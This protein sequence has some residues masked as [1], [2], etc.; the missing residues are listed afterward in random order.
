MV[1]TGS[2]G[3]EGEDS[4][5]LP[6]W[7]FN[8]G[9]TIIQ[10]Q[11]VHHKNDRRASH[12]GPLEFTFPDGLLTKL[13][14]THIKQGHKV[15]TQA[16]GEKVVHLFVSRYSNPFSA[17]TFN[18]YWENLMQRVDT[19]GQ[20]YFAPSLART[21]YVEDYT[22]EQGVHPDMWDGAAAVMGNSVNVW[23]S[24]NPSKRKR[25]AQRAVDAHTE[26]VTRRLHVVDE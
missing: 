23:S 8:Y 15:L 5:S 24:Y 11:V 3:D 7:H 16:K 17:T 4:E 14:L 18:H 13:L 6:P 9:S 10:I 1:A 19:M 21:M 20:P 12:N 26:Y 25:A 22:S 2:D